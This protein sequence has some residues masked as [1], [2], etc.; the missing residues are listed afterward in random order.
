MKQKPKLD[1]LVRPYGMIPGF[2]CAFCLTKFNSMVKVLCW[3]VIFIKYQPDMLIYIV[4]ACYVF[5]R[6]VEQVYSVVALS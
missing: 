6:P 3:K 2:L 4:A 1:A 5:H